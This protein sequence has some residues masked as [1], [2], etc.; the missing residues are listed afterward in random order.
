MASAFGIIAN[1][2]VQVEVTAIERIEDAEGNILYQATPTQ[3]KVTEPAP[4]YVLANL[5]EGVFEEGGTASRVSSIIKR[6][7]AGKTGSTDTDAWM[8]G[9]TPEL[10]TAV[11]IGYDKNKII[12][13]VESHL[14]TPI[15]AEFTERSLEAIPPKLF[16]IPQGVVNVYIDPAS[17]KLANADCPNSRME[18]FLAGTE[19]TTYCTDRNAAPQTG[20]SKPTSPKGKNGTWWEDLKR[21]WNN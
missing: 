21:W 5:M 9:F 10:S 14:A 3:T 1:Q 20:E 19:P 2:G 18:V 17:G 12:G 6:P 16:P 11:W 13:N 7:I 15:F 4:A 8:V